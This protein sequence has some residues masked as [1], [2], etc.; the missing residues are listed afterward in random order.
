MRD[1]A[2]TPLVLRRVRAHASDPAPSETREA[3]AAPE[4]PIAHPNQTDEP[5]MSAPKALPSTLP[6]AGCTSPTCIQ[7]ARTLAIRLAGEACARALKQAIA[8][9]PL[10]VARFVGDA[11]TAAGLPADATVRLCALD[12]PVCRA[13]VAAAIEVDDSLGRGDVIVAACDG[14]LRAVLD[15]R[16]AL[17]VRAASDV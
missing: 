8:K 17:L 7:R 6:D 2:F 3:I 15:E 12:A 1:D 11:L 13:G 16:A 5:G 4:E 9:N 10:F 14:T